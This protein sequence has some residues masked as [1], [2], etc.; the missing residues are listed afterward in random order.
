MKT[1]IFIGQ[2]P[3][4]LNGY[5]SDEL[6]LARI[7]N[8]DTWLEAD[9]RTFNAAN[10]SIFDRAKNNWIDALLQTKSKIDGKFLSP[11]DPSASLNV[12]PYNLSGLNVIND[13]T[14]TVVVNVLRSDTRIIFG[15][16]SSDTATLPLVIGINKNDQV[17]IWE[18]SFF[19]RLTSNSDEVKRALQVGKSAIITATFSKTKGITLWLNGLKVAEN[20][21]DK[22]GLNS[23]KSA[24]PAD[25]GVSTGHILTHSKDLSRDEN[26][27]EMG[28]LQQ[29]L[30]DYYG[31]P[32][33]VV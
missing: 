27:A 24:M 14:V 9:V 7:S 31:I 25:R 29:T 28:L 16:R 15:G 2:N 13:A 5:R 21:D 1:A 19:P 3:T 33:L 18:K 26:L 4:Q 11:F 8:C 17:S 20:K 6:A 10:F 12:A 22:R 23:D 32:K 30:L